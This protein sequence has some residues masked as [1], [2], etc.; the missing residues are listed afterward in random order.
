MKNIELLK[1]HLKL[2]NT[3]TKSSI[4]SQFSLVTQNKQLKAI[5]QRVN[6][7]TFYGS[8]IEP[9]RNEV[10]SLKF[11]YENVMEENRNLRSMMLEDE[12][13]LNLVKEETKKMNKLITDTRKEKDNIKSNFIQL[14]KHIKLMREKVISL[15][16]KNKK[17]LVEFYSLSL[18]QN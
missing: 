12:K 11:E 10:S 1:S 4:K 14:Q 18:D 13:E 17:I 7:E 6:N 16:E 9:I 15:D 5:E 3:E 2:N 8:G